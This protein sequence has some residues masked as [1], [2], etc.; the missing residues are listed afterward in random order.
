MTGELVFITGGSGHLGYRVIVDALQAGYRVRAAI[1][2]QSKASQI[3]SAPSIKA[4]NPGDRLEFV[5][6]P[7]LL[8]DSAYD[9]AVK[10]AVYI[11]HCASPITSSYAQGTDMEEHFVTPAV[12]GTL[13]ILTAAQRA[14]T[15]KRVVITSSV[16][17]VIAFK[18][19]T[20]GKIH[21]VHNEKSR[22]A[23]LHGPY[24][25]VMEAYSASKIKALNETEAWIEQEKPS[26]D[27]VNI[28]PGFIIGQ[29]ELVTDVKDAM[30]GTNKTVLGPVTGGGDG[31]KVPGT[32]IHLLDV[33]LAH[34]KALDPKVPAQAYALASEGV[35]GTDWATSWDI[36]SKEF[37]DAVKSGVLSQGKTAMLP[38]PFDES[39]SEELLGFKFRSFEEQVK[40]VVGRYIELKTAV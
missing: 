35:K 14:S 15:V 3:L 24:H 34:V 27:V 38:L 37:P 12:K 4:I 9:E 33:A 30:Y 8:A 18:D 5:E 28:L 40:D 6:V 22:T 13:S 19:F 16:V 26:F 31:S 11:I 32:S 39:R 25:S 23:F 36:V 2:S 1:R 7:D 21:T 10:D 20:S 29:N 17:A